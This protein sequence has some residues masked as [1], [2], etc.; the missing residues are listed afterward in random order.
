EEASGRE[1][2]DRVRQRQYEA[3]HL[4]CRE[5]FI[6]TD[7]TLKSAEIQETLSKMGLDAVVAACYVFLVLVSVLTVRFFY[8]LWHSGQPESRLCTTR[9]RCLN[10]LGSDQIAWIVHII[11]SIVKKSP[12]R[13]RGAALVVSLTYGTLVWLQIERERPGN[14]DAAC[15]H[16][17]GNNGNICIG[18]VNK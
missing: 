12:Q 10:V 3:R 7:A 18:P 13:G 11:T 1:T 15:S 2:T 5:T 6:L 9:L 4:A 14:S 8:V 16:E 17:D